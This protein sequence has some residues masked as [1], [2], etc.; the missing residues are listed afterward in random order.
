[1][2]RDAVFGVKER[3]VAE[4]ADHAATEPPPPGGPA[5]SDWS[6][7]RYDFVLAPDERSG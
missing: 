5:S 6:S 3:L 2:G 7:V 4:F 1:L